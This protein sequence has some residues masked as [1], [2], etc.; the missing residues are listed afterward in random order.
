MANPNL[1]NYSSQLDFSWAVVLPD[2]NAQNLIGNPSSSNSVM[3]VDVWGWNEDG[4][5]PVDVTI[6]LYNASGTPICNATQSGLTS[7]VTTTTDTVA[8]T[9]LAGPTRIQ[10]TTNNGLQFVRRFTLNEGMSLVFTATN[11][12]DAGIWLD[13]SVF[14]A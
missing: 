9:P 8:G 5:V 3:K 13:Y 2:T 4:L 11:G 10:L 14:T 1:K 7:G 12:G 6:K